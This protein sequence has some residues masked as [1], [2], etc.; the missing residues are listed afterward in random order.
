MLF[1][2][3]WKFTFKPDVITLTIKLI[4]NFLEIPKLQKSQCDETESKT[5]MEKDANQLDKQTL[6]T[7]RLFWQVDSF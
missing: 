1:I 3:S 5:A 2:Q 7:K 4:I 6:R